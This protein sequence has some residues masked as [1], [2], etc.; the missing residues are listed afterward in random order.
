MRTRYRQQELTGS[1]EE[2]VEAAGNAHEEKMEAAGSNEDK[3]F[4]DSNYLISSGP[5]RWYVVPRV[6]R[7]LVYLFQRDWTSVSHAPFQ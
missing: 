1:T 2:K 5:Q 7:L 3:H 4:A 6:R